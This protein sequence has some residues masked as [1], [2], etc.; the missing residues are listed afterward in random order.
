MT[1]ELLSTSSEKGVIEAEQLRCRALEQQDY[2]ELRRMISTDITHT[3]T[4][5]VTDDFESYFRFIEEDLEFLECS[6]GPLTVRLFGRVAVMTGPMRNVVRR[7]GED[8]R[9]TTAAQVLQVWEWRSNRWI[10]VAFQS[11]SLPKQG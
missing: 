4:R 7:R 1:M 9:I 10:L 6:R 11:T 5:G 2:A 8:S 3:H